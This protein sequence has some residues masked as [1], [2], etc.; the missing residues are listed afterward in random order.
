MKVK[1]TIKKLKDIQDISV[2]KK[3]SKYIG[4]SDGEVDLDVGGVY[5]VYGV[6]FWEN[7][8]WYYLCADGVEYPKPYSSFFLK[9]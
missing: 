9:L 2:S 1:C 8:P 3:L 7:H 4:G 5:T 6:E